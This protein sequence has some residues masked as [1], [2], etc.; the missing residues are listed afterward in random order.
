MPVDELY[1]GEL[2][3]GMAATVGLLRGDAPPMAAEIRQMPRSVDRSSGAGLVILD[4]VGEAPDLPI[5]LSLDV[6]LEVAEHPGALVVPRDAVV[7]IGSQPA[8][9]RLFETPAVEG[10]EP[11]QRLERVGVEVIEWPSERL[12]VREGL[13]EGDLIAVDPRSAATG[14]PVRADA[15]DQLPGAGPASGD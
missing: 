10:E 5:G 9:L 8:V 15:S 2:R 11:E 12:V 3:V 13:N 4:F 14:V 7:G 1:L 6:N